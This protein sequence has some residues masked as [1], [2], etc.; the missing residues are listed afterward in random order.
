MPREQGFTLI[1]VLVVVALIA[2]LLSI[3]LPSLSGAKKRAQA[4]ACMNNLKQFGFAVQV[5][6]HEYKGFLPGEGLADGDTAANPVGPWDDPSF[7]A[8][9]LPTII[10]RKTLAGY[11][12][13]QEVHMAG[14]T[15]L[16]RS[17]DS[18]LFVCPSASPAAF[19][20][21]PAEVN[22]DG[23]FMM[24]GLKPGSKTLE[25][26]REQRPT[27]WC[28]VFNSGLDNLVNVGGGT[29]DGFGTRHL[30]SDA[31]KRQGEVPVLVEK[32]MNP[33]ESQPRFN[34]RLNRAKTKGNSWDSCRLA[35][36]HRA[37]ANLLFVD[38]HVGWVSRQ[39]A[40]TDYAGDGSYAQTAQIVWQPK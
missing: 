2:L 17:G 27:Y 7:W 25:G 18:S 15:R 39:I 22:S 38:S 9:V 30:K 37:G 33:D 16:P 11:C 24:W 10:S 1:E 12:K 29:V 35:S 4:V 34:N 31:I 21:T 32:M 28:Y 3:L 6:G 23:Y 20:Q 13:M 19:G 14:G 40:T 8:N 5:Y 26:P 36:R